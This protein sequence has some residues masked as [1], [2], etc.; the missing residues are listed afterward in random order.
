[1]PWEDMTASRVSLTPPFGVTTK[2]M[3][4]KLFEQGRR[5]KQP[6]SVIHREKINGAS[7]HQ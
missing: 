7:W 4:D 3:T 5:D 2:Y 6:L 1:M